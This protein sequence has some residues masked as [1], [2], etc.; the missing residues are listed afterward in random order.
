MTGFQ[1]ITT[2]RLPAAK[3]RR[4][5]GLSF[6]LSVEHF[7]GRDAQTGVIRSTGPRGQ[8]FTQSGSESAEALECVTTTIVLRPN[9]AGQ[10]FGPVF[11]G[12]QL[13]RCD[14][15]RHSVSRESKPEVFAASSR[16]DAALLLV[17]DE[18]QG[19]RQ[20]PLYRREHPVG[21]PFAPHEDDEVIRVPH[22]LQAAAF[23]FRVQII[24]QDV[25]QQG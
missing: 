16:F 6:Q 21:T 10:F 11:E 13:L 3:G 20:I 17:H 1:S 8:S 23:Q 7:F 25:R 2:Q 9:V 14:G 18:F 15:D 22:E 24:P 12:F 4:F 5:L 19:L